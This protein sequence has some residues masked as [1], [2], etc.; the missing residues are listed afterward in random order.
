MSVAGIVNVTGVPAVVVWFA[1]PPRIVRLFDPSLA[2]VTANG[3]L[4]APVP[5]SDVTS[6]FAVPENPAVGT[7]FTTAFS[8]S[9]ITVADVIVIVFTGL[10]FSYG[11]VCW[12]VTGAVTAF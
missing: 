5:S 12:F 3:S 11:N 1:T 4:T 10:L 2:G 7:S 6:M 9:T 8:L